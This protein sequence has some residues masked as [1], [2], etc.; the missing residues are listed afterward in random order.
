MQA[1]S[2]LA[3]ASGTWVGTRLT[4]GM[5]RLTEHVGGPA[6]RRVVLLLLACVLSLDA[7][8]QGAIGAV[9]PDLTQS[10]HISN[11]SSSRASSSAPAWACWWRG[12]WRAGSDGARR[13]GS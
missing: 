6:R 1:V 4:G 12:S 10:L 5:E 13:S 3:R 7:A 11:T 8:D 9:A 2:A